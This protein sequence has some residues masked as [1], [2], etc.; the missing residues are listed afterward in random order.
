MG[1]K[2]ERLRFLQFISTDLSELL[3]SFASSFA[4][5]CASASD[6]RGIPFIVIKDQLTKERLQDKEALRANFQSATAVSNV[7]KTSF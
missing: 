2:K 6:E 3:L 7:I 4:S 1:M 5:I